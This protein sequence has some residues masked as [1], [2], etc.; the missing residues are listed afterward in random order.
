MVLAMQVFGL[1]GDIAGLFLGIPHALT[2]IFSP[3]FA[4]GPQRLAQP[5]LVGGDQARGR[6]QDAGV[7]R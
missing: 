3:G 1:G 6:A 5:A 4:F 2:R 7:E